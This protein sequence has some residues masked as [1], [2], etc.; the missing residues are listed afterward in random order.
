MT[1][2]NE[3][4]RIKEVYESR[5]I[6]DLKER[7]YLWHPCSPVSVYYR[8]AQERAVISLVNKYLLQ[9]E[10]IH[11]LDVG[12]GTGNYLRFMLSLG[13]APENLHGIDLIPLRI[14]YARRT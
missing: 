9:L 14:D 4:D 6:P 13:A 5:S 7:G 8:Q 1:D 3:I 12:C 2:S 10:T 11:L